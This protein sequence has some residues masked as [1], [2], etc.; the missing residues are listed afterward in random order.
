MNPLPEILE[1]LKAIFFRRR[2]ERELDEEL[3]YHVDRETEARERSG[4]ADPRRD[5]LM[6]LGGVEKWKDDVRDARGVLPLEE[7]VADTRY[8]LRALRRNA[9][10]TLSVMAVL[11]IGI[12]AATAVF[13]VVNR[14]LLS[15]LPYPESDR[16]VAINQK[17][18]SGSWTLSVVDLQ[19]IAAQQRTLEAFG[20]MRWGSASV[21]GSGSA[22][23]VTIGRVTS[24]FFRALGIHAAQGRL[25][26]AGDDAPGA[27][28]AVVI[29]SA[30]AERTFG[31]AAESVG[32]AVAIDGLSHLVVGVLD[33]GRHELAGVPAEVWPVLH[34]ATPK[35]RGPF[36]YR[37]VAR[38]RK[39]VTIEAAA[40]D[41]D[42]ISRR[43]FPLWAAGFQ[44][45]SA[46]LTPVPLRDTIVGRANRQVGLFAGAVALVLLLAIANVATLVVVRIS[47][48][49]QELSVRAALG[50]GRRRLVQLILI[51]CLT[52]TALSGAAG[53]ALAALALKGVRLVA[54]DLPRL[55][56][57]AL[58]P[59]AAAF[60]AAAALVAGLLISLAPVSSVLRHG[61]ARTS[62]LAS[63]SARVGSG[64]RTHRIR[65]AL[66]VAEFALALPL[67]IGA[68][69][70]LNSFL[71]LQSVDPGFDP[72]GLYA[73]EIS[74]PP[75]RYPDPPATLAFW[76]RVEQRA[77]ATNGLT[78]AG[79]S[80]SMAPDNFGDVNNF[81][82]LD[83]PVPAGTTQPASPW[84]SVTTGYFAAM[85]IP[86]LEGRS[87]TDADSGDAPPVVVVSRSWAARYYPH[88]SPVGK[89]LVSGGC[90]TCPPTTVVGVVGDVRYRGLAGEADAVYS[91]IAQGGDTSGYLVVRSRLGAA[92]TLQ[93]LRSIVASLDPNIA[94]VEVVM[95]DRLRQALGDP[96]RWT[97]VVGAF[98][99][100][101]AL[102]AALGIFGLMSYVV[103]QRR[104]ELGVRIA[105]GA[106]PGSLIGLVV[107]GGMRYAVLGTAIGLGISVFESRWLGSSLYGVRAGD[108]ATVAGAVAALMAIAAIACWVPGFRAGRIRPADVLR[109]E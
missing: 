75:A 55:S 80:G 85:G 63:S 59:A 98:A 60:V 26:E 89:R 10:F 12:G 102:L 83:K 93:A 43:I 65:G 97:A 51:E 77:V 73:V 25:L 82:L 33:P 22:E 20:G 4:S 99:A 61:R 100:A 74:L 38:L 34:L 86:R 96:R 72:R 13:T 104:R 32:R 50:A 62:T 47:A 66:V 37:A 14:V 36:G 5:A 64:P 3:Q 90:T 68:G 69:L 49:E 8:A 28:P 9:G 101:G 19:A 53:L 44:D 16:L 107:G 18:S 48:R 46:R 71:R 27:P 67:L 21:N 17:S 54:P 15:S 58:D 42:G 81:D 23:R 84:P 92:A 103:R 57:L 2:V 45:A 95:T 29:T 76:R 11:G 6:S 105:L 56:E 31:G 87:F 91:P 106:Q 24:G 39:G 70:L 108:P 30:F 52:L 78:A 7:C 35:R 88:Q 40:R 109:A 41:L 1:R 94:P 79:L